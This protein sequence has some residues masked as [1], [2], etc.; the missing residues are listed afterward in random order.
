MPKQKFML[1]SKE[2]KFLI[3][4]QHNSTIKLIKSKGNFITPKRAIEDENDNPSQNYSQ[5]PTPLPEYRK[6]YE[7]R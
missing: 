2:A 5:A 1:S 4:E 6:R 7:N 3:P